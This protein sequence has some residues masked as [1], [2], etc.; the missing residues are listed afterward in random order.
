M[1]SRRKAILKA[2]E[3]SWRLKS[4]AI[5]LEG[6]DENTK[7]FQAYAKGRKLCNTIWNLQ[8]GEDR[9]V[10][11]FEG[12]A[13]LGRDHFQNLFKDPVG[14]STS[15]VIRVA[16]IFPRYV[17]VDDNRALVEEVF[18]EELKIALAIFQKDKSPRP[19]GWGIGFF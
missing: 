16:Q 17:D 5:W 6:G 15:E 4:R 1:D 13:T 7:F 8:D 2:Q 19:D 9:E 11:S 14:A 18:E 10:S 3:A 12:L